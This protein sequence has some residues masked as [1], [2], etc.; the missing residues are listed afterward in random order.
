[1]PADVL[2]QVAEWRSEGRG[3]ALATVIATWGSSPRPAGS[4]LAV[5]E[6]GRMSGS[7]SGGCVEGAV[8]ETAREV[9]ET[10]AHQVLDFGVTD[11]MAWEVGLACGGEMQVFVERVVRRGGAPEQRAGWLDRLAADRAAKRPVVATVN[12]STGRRELLRPAPPDVT[13]RP[14][15]AEIAVAT[16]EALRTDAASILE[17][18]DGRLFLQPFNPPLRLVIV[19]AVHIAQPLSRMAAETGYEVIV[20]DPRGAFASDARF[21]GTRLERDWPDEALAALALDSRT[22]V[23][24]LTHDPKLD[25]PALQVAL[26]SPAFYVGSLG[27]R[28]TQDRRLA[29]LRAEGFGE[30]EL[31]RLHGPVGLDIG[32]R[33]PAEIAVAILGQVTAR[34]RGRTG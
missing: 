28:R 15:Q 9:I 8:V 10:G 18:R 19:G 21:P 6:Q 7:V 29:R 17:R 13:P 14:D 22:A 25:D 23:V 2:E 1:M 16:R 27:S 12:L 24:T 26:R 3:V 4:Q 32:A 11:E 31:A 5:D 20:V 30:R 34:L 33:S